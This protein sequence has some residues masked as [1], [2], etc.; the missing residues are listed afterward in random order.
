MKKIHILLVFLNIISIF[1]LLQIVFDLFP[2]IECDYSTNKIEKIN[3]LVISLSIAI[4]TSTLFYILLVYLPEKK[5]SITAREVSSTNLRFL[6]ENM[7]FLI[8][9]LI[10]SYGIK[11]E[12]NDYNFSRINIDEFSKI[13]PNI[14]CKE[15]I[16]GHYEIF[17]RVNDK[18]VSLGTDEINLKNKAT[19]LMELIQ[20]TLSTP[21]IIFEDE[22]L[23][24][25][26]NRIHHCSFFEAILAFT[27]KPSFKTEIPYSPTKNVTD[28]Y[29]LYNHL[30]KYTTPHN[31]YFEKR[32]KTTEN[33]DLLSNLANNIKN[34]SAPTQ[35]AKKP[36]KSKKKK[37]HK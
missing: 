8:I 14:F 5:K 10:K 21:S 36:N 16:S 19:S 3:N 22:N 2:I 18:L 15:Q 6:A 20:K 9:H 37:K 26:L 17:I 13:K 24:K 4:I 11:V 23:I 1:F 29:L 27:L 33:D 30:L 32:N 31:F 12:K 7:Q 34:I 25:L 35:T 28:F